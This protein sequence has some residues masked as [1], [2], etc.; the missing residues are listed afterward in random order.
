MS[1]PGYYFDNQREARLCRQVWEIAPRIM[2]DSRY[3]LQAP[4]GA[5]SK[6][7]WA[8]LRIVYARD[9]ITYNREMGSVNRELKSE[10]TGTEI[11]NVEHFYCGAILGMIG[12]PV[13]GLVLGGVGAVLWDGLISPI[14][15]ACSGGLTWKGLKYDL[16]QVGVYD[17]RGTYFGAMYRIKGNA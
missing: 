6:L 14:R 12:G 5:F 15:K 9:W 10:Y 1:D 2:G 11:A 4:H 8:S 7:P 17:A 16:K 13:A 3:T